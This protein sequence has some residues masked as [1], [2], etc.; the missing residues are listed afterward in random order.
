LGCGDDDGAGGTEGRE[1]V[2]DA[3]GVNYIATRLDKKSPQV[4]DSKDAILLVYPTPG[5]LA[6]EAVSC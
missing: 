3:M 5:I 2:V 6:K 1:T 4:A